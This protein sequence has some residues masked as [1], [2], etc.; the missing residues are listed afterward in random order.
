MIGKTVSHYRIVD[1]LGGGGMGV[2]Y[3]ASD[4]RLGRDV[5]LK[6]LPEEVAKD[7]LAVERFQREA[8]AA[9]GLNHPNICTIYDVDEHE[10]QPFI[11][12]ELLEGETLKH[13]ISGKP[14]AIDEVVEIATQISDALE[15]THA[16]GIIHRDIKPANLFVTRRGQAKILDFGLA[17]LAPQKQRVGETIG[18]TVA[19]GAMGDHLTTSGSSIGTVAYMSPEQARGEEVDA[20]TDLFSLGV[21][22][23]EMVTGREAFGGTAA[24]V[25]FDSILNRAPMPIARLNPAVPQELDHTIGRLMEKDR[26][27]RI[28]SAAKLHSELVRMKRDVDSGRGRAA[29]AA[30]TEKSLAVLYF[31]N[32]SAQ[33]EDEYFRDGMTEDVITELLKV[34]GMKVFPRAAV[35]TFRDKAVTAPQVGQELG[36]MYVLSGSIRRAGN[37]L[38]VT[39]QLVEAGT[40]HGVWADRFDRTLEDVFEVQDEIARS[41]TQA[42]RITLSPQEE[43]A[44]ARK[45]TENAEAYDYFLRGRGYARRLTRTDLEFALQMYEHAVERDPNFALAHAEMAI[46]CSEIYYFHDA[47]QKWVDQGRRAYERALELDPQL[48]E[49]YAARASIQEANKEFDEAIRSA[50]RALELNPNYGNAYF[51]LGR[52]LFRGDRPAEAADLAQRAI[53][54]GGDDYNVFVPYIMALDRVGRVAEADTLRQGRVVALERQ[55][56]MVPEDARARILLATNYAHFKKNDAAMNEVKKALE[57]RPNDANILYNAA[58]TYGLMEKKADALDLLKKMKANGFSQLDWAR[59]DPDLSCLHNDPEFLALLEDDKH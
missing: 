4:N 45:P 36:A 58:C 57:L 25:V 15:A 33:K 21:V 17:K 9:S 13:H 54:I 35:L 12:M 30:S 42:L 14:M 43:R 51:S 55:L 28:P 6:F 40:G 53:E 20:R 23:Y 5:A 46:A 10:G 31:E 29:A 48:G 11:V 8:R 32:L 56:E 24:A 44:I 18:A 1:K 22:L 16:H 39:A 19:V 37:R 50:R 59:R 41:I 52:A 34:K 2:V 7:K 26:E 49:A 38:R 3:R 47:N 27:R